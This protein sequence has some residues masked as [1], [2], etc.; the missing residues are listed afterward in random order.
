MNE[1]T[2]D[3]EAAPSQ[4]VAVREQGGAVGIL[5]P[6][7]SLDRIA[8]AFKEYQRVCET[9]LDKTDYQ[10]Y[11]GKPRKKKSAWRKLATAFNVST[12][13][14]SEEIERTESRHV[15]SASYTICA[16]SG[17]KDNPHRQFEAVGYCDI[18]EK[19]C[20]SQRG[21]KCHKAAWKGHYCCAKGCDGRKH[22]SHPDHDVKSTAQ[23]RASNR[24][25]ADLIGCGEV[26][27]EELTDDA[28]PGQNGSG[29]AHRSPPPSTSTPR[30]KA[31]GT[32]SA[33]PSPAQ[34][35]P[36]PAK[37]PFPTPESRSKMIAA[38]NAGPGQPDRV[39]VEDY[40]RKLENPAQLAPFEP[41]EALPLRFVP[42]TTGQMRDLVDRIKHFANGDPA[43]AAFPPH[44]EPEPTPKASP[45]GAGGQNPPYSAATG[46]ETLKSSPTPAPAPTGTSSAKAPKDD[47]WWRDVI[48]P[49]PHKGQ[50]RQ[51]YEAHPETI[52]QLFD[53]RH[54]QDEESQAARQ[55]LWGFIN[56]YEAKGWTKRDGT[57]MLP[58]AHDLKF[59]EALDALADWHERNCPG[60]KL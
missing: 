35:P 46:S 47:E 38:L 53:M 9:I 20:P 43:A 27:A 16:Y 40:F 56:H 50:S 23:T 3:V 37:I 52:G 11:E 57:Q 24:A 26:S 31:S 22:W 32:G 44:P 60:E 42:A 12:R 17:P 33:G 10:V 18:N 19:C 13:V 36:N 14:V 21:E 6:A 51:E 15:L 5:R 59:R 29:Q 2:I 55:R 4:A 7:D 8:E 48:V 45:K 34:K 41:L 49:V 25:I 1:S 28:P 58:S 30:A 54:G 39:T